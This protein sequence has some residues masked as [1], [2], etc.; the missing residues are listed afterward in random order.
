M[1]RCFC[2]PFLF[3]DTHGQKHSRLTSLGALVILLVF[4]CSDIAFLVHRTRRRLSQLTAAT[5]PPK[6]GSRDEVSI[7]RIKKKT[8]QMSGFFLWRLKQ[9]SILARNALR[10]FAVLTV[11]R[12]VIHYRSYRSPTAHP[13]DTADSRNVSAETWFT[14]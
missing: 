3:C 9:D 7:E 6:H 12:T 11:H 5:Y 8:T 1:R 10:S 13:C 4:S 14:R 2:E